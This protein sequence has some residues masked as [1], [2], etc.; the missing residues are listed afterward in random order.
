[1]NLYKVFNSKLKASQCLRLPNLIRWNRLLRSHLWLIRDKSLLRT[2]IET[3][4]SPSVRKYLSLCPIN[5]FIREINLSIPP[6]VTSHSMYRRRMKN[7]RLNLRT[8]TFHLETF[9]HPPCREE[10][11][12]CLPGKRFSAKRFIYLLRREWLNRI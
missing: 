8:L 5:L 12:Q 2:F 1:M 6:W 3:T 11:L 9:I 4:L 7:F 10:P